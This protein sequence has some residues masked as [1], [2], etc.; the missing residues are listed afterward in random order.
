MCLIPSDGNGTFFDFEDPT[1]P[2]TFLGSLTIQRCGVVILQAPISENT[3]GFAD[4]YE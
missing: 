2:Y 4:I 1:T 3:Q